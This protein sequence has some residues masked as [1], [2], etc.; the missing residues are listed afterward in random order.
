MTVVGNRS[1]LRFAALDV[2]PERWDVTGVL[3]IG[4]GAIKPRETK[5]GRAIYAECQSG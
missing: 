3:A 1:L 5:L 4:S 2:Q